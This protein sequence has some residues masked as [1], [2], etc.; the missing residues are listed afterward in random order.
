[1]RRSVDLDNSIGIQGTDPD[2]LISFVGRSIDNATD[3]DLVHAEKPERLEVDE[4]RARGDI[5][6]DDRHLGLSGDSN[7]YV[8]GFGIRTAIPGDGLRRIVAR[9]A[10]GGR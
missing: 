8:F 10:G 7:P 5:G 9:L 6:R 1:M 4:L 2:R 3:D